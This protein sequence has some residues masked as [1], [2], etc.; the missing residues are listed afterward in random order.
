MQI[1]EQ[2][3]NEVLEIGKGQLFNYNGQLYMVPDAEFMRNEY[4]RM[5]DGAV[6]K[7]AP[8]TLVVWAQVKFSSPKIELVPGDTFMEDGD[9]YMLLEPAFE[10][11]IEYGGD[12]PTMIEVKYERAVRLADGLVIYKVRPDVKVDV[13]VKV[14]D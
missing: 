10:R 13:V 3:K 5:S 2:I 7:M 9:V 1:E 4:I 14:Q 12:E 8:N 11:E 6:V